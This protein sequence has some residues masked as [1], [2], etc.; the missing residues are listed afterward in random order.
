MKANRAHEPLRGV[1]AERWFKKVLVRL[2]L[3]VEELA[4]R[5]PAHNFS[6]LAWVR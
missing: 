1:E 2:G 6:Q 3:K 4:E 5:H